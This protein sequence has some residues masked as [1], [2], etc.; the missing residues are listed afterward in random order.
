MVYETAGNDFRVSE[1]KEEELRGAPDTLVA[2][3]STRRFTGEAAPALEAY[4][5]ARLARCAGAIRAGM[6]AGGNPF[7]NSTS[8]ENSPSSPPSPLSPL[9]VG[10][11]SGIVA[12]LASPLVLMACTYSCWRFRVWRRAGR[13][14]R[15]P[16]LEMGERRGERGPRVEMP[17]EEEEE[18]ARLGWEGAMVIARM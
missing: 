15:E 1:G 5:A 4:V 14:G 7:K 10:L 3:S 18:E 8:A 6:G 2:L 17:Q 11:V 9:I 12:S 13:S 16:D